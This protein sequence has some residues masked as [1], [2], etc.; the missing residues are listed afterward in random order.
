MTD[1][2]KHE[3][4]FTTMAKGLVDAAGPNVLRRLREA[5]ALSDEQLA[6]ELAG[7]IQPEA[8]QWLASWDE[9]R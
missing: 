7:R 9:S 6:G 5:F 8:G 2:T 3:G 1:T 4:R